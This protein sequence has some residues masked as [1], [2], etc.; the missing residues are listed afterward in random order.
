[1]K[2]RMILSIVLLAFILITIC[3][4]VFADEKVIVTLNAEDTVKKGDTVTVFVNINSTSS[5]ITGLQGKLNY[6]SSILEYISSKS[7]KQGWF[8]SG[9]N[10]STG[11]FLVEISDV[12]NE[13]AYIKNGSENVVSFTFRV[14][15]NTSAS[16][17]LVEVSN[18]VLSGTNE[19]EENY[20][21][22]TIRIIVD[23]D[24]DT[25][26]DTDPDSN[27]NIDGDSDTDSN[28]IVDS[29]SNNNSSNR[30]DSKTGS[31]SK[32]TSS[33]SN[34]P[35]TGID[36]TVLFGFVFLIS[37]SIASYYGYKKYKEI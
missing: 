21:S 32:K 35:T 18:I 7:E 10:E 13:N 22:K 12:S 31:S 3:S 17:T 16:E 9:F 25:D 19:L 33:K 30:K 27:P 37:I 24:S 34:M 1:M 26:T 5:S 11:M 20:A 8:V 4:K 2:K 14:K 29:D 36:N 28:P 15:A 23:T 6:D